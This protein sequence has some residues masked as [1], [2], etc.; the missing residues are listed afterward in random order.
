MG[1]IL[2]QCFQLL[3]RIFGQIWPDCYT[4]LAALEKFSSKE[5]PLDKIKSKKPV[6]IPSSTKFRHL[7][8]TALNNEALP[9]NVSH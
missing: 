4:N 1:E 2:F 7:G 3:S 6:F 5:K 8:N 9:F